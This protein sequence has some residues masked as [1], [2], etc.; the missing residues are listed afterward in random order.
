[1]PA[2]K[3][4]PQRRNTSAAVLGAAILGLFLAA[5]PTAAQDTE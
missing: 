4:T 1:M 2:V 5:V 3:S